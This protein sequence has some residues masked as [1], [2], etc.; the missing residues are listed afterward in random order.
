MDVMIVFGEKCLRRMSARRFSK[1]SSITTRWSC[2]LSQARLTFT[3][4][5][6]R[7]TI[8]KLSRIGGRG[9]EVSS[10][11][12]ADLAPPLERFAVERLLRAA[13][14]TGVITFAGLDD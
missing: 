14:G 13:L 1:E 11:W 2:S 10:C 7:R 5:L 6:I 9:R 4:S 8:R 12:Y 3:S